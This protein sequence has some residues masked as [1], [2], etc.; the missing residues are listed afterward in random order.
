M[1]DTWNFDWKEENSSFSSDAKS[2]RKYNFFP[3]IPEAC[4]LRKMS[5][6]NKDSALQEEYSVEKVLQKRTRNGKVRMWTCSNVS[7]SLKMF[8]FIRSSI[9]WNGKVTLTRTTHG[10]QKKTWIAPNWSQPSR[11]TRR[12]VKVLTLPAF[13]WNVTDCSIKISAAA[14][15]AKKRKADP[16][17]SKTATKKKSD[18]KEGF[19]RGLQPERI[20]GATDTS[21][22]LMFLMKWKDTDEADLVPAKQANVKCPQIVIQFYEERLTW[23]SNTSDRQNQW[24]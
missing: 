15:D 1:L 11:I 7:L 23:H 6:T 24:R 10:S 9:T 19:D 20:I 5:K 22:E 17:E 16:N 2:S 14:T 4:N 12:S 18:R 13:F 3:Q 21:G 8:I